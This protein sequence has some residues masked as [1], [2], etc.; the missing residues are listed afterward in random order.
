M[1][2]YV[3]KRARSLSHTHT[4]TQAGVVDWVLQG[5]GH[6]SMSGQWHHSETDEGVWI[7]VRE[8]RV[9][10][11]FSLAPCLQSHK[12]EQAAAAA[13]EVE[14]AVQGCH[15]RDQSFLLVGC[16]AHGRALHVTGR[17]P[18]SVEVTAIVDAAP[19]AAQAGLSALVAKG[20][21]HDDWAV[22][23]TSAL[24]VHWRGLVTE[25]ASVRLGVPVTVQ[26][27]YDGCFGRIYLNG[28]LCTEGQ[29]R[30]LYLDQTA[31]DLNEELP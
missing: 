18:M 20:D 11:G 3:C 17:A 23:V 6:G 1:Y 9:T 12:S 10:R 25:D 29:V 26:C 7:G 19:T 8:P 21:P 5:P 4:H 24:A 22:C 13:A 27:T 14:L 31:V 30:V 28:R 16:G 15:L 2:A